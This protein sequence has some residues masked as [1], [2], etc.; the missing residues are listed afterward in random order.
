[1]NDERHAEHRGGHGDAE[2]ERFWEDHYRR[3]ERV[4]SGRPNPVLV[5]VAGSLRP[6][7]VLDL[8]CGEGGDAIW[9][10]RRGW[11]VSAVDMSATALERA[12][13]DADAA[14]V[15]DR[16]DFRRHDLALTFPSGAFDLVSAQYLHSPVE[17]PRVHVLQQ[18]ASA[19]TPG[20]LLLIVDHASVSPRSWAAPEETLAPLD[21]SPDEWRT[22][23]IEA[24]EREAIRPN[25]QGI[26]VTDNI[27]VVRRVGG[28]S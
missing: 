21:L 23:R 27:V 1:M 6:G 25:G 18:A 12:A 3:R 8:G 20:G 2:A 26:T 19:V 4:W 10:A 9:L 14:G 5:D 24:R 22:E 28:R 17:F 11:R 16:I 15:A 13:E 7:T